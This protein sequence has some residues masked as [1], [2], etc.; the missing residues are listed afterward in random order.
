MSNATAIVD[1]LL[2]ADEVDPKQFVSR[3]THRVYYSLAYFQDDAY[4][5][6]MFEFLD[7]EGEQRTLE[8][9]ADAWDRLDVGG[10][11]EARPVP[12]YGSHDE[13][14]SGDYEGHRYILSYNRSLGYIGL[15][16]V[17]HEFNASE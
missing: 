8:I 7:N 11:H 6:E 2:E 4:A 9:M 17:E 13:V 12:S 5:R 14:Y 1:T 3:K 15:D 10:D 16:R